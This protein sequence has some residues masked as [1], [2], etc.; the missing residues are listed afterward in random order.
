VELQLD[1]DPKAFPCYLDMAT[2][3]RELRHW[4]LAIRALRRAAAIEPAAAAPRRGLTKHP[5]NRATR[6]RLPSGAHRG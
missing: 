6:S 3:Y 5:A 2:L 4:D 1:A